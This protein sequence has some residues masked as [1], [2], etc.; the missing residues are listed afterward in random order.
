MNPVGQDLVARA[1]IDVID[2]C[3]PNNTHREIA[4]AAIN[5]GKMVFCEKPLA[6]NAAEALQMAEAAEQAGNPTM[7]FFNY[8]RIPAITLAKRM[9][10]NGRLGRIFHYRAKY[11]QDWTI[12]PALPQGG[13]TLW[14]FDIEAAGS[15]V[16]GDLLAHSIDQALW[17][18]GPIAEVT[19]MTATFVK[20]RALQDDPSQVKPVG[21]DDA[22][23]FLA[24]FE[25]G[26]LGTFELMRYACG[27][28]NQNDFEI[29]GERGAIAFDLENAHQLQYYNHADDST[30]R[31]FRTVPVWDSDHPYM[32]HWWVPGC[33]IGYE[34]TFIHQVSDFLDQLESDEKRVPDFGDGYETQRVCDAVLASART[35]VW[36]A[37]AG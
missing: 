28:K 25:S 1:D 4:L 17:L 22:C 24:R 10:D 11:L 8:R 34:H 5:A 29:N 26:A 6:M 13:N 7:V 33:A 35:G 20:E 9:I 2:I 3:T 27:R 19:A 32:A 31:G 30:V 23:A 14:R 16:T 18:A 15:G 12:N 36:H 37:V 21:I